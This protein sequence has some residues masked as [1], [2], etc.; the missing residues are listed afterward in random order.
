MGARPILSV[1]VDISCGNLIKSVSKR[2]VETQWD[3]EGVPKKDTML[4]DNF[5]GSNWLPE[6]HVDEDGNLTFLFK[7]TGKSIL[8]DSPNFKAS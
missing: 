7:L 4:V 8:K 3:D 2:N 1:T 5:F 6:D